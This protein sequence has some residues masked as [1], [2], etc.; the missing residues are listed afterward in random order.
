MAGIQYVIG[1]CPV[2]LTGSTP[3]ANTARRMW[4]LHPAQSHQLASLTDDGVVAVGDALWL[5]LRLVTTGL[6][7]ALLGPVRRGD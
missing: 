7:S 6:E 1:T 4:H 2:L 5:P 3:S